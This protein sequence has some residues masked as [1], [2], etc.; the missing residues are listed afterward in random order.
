MIKTIIEDNR[1]IE[2]LFG[3]NGK[4]YIGDGMVTKIIPYL[5]PGEMGYTTW[6]AI[7]HNDD[8]WLKVSSKYYNVHYSIE[9]KR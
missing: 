7:Y 4:H 2:G 3:P 9:I 5:E 6:F 8:I 1:E